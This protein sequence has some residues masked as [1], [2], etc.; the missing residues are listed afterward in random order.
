MATII[1]GYT[2]I[3]KSREDALSKQKFSY[4]NWLETFSFIKPVKQL[5]KPVKTNQLFILD[6][7]KVVLTIYVINFH[8]DSSFGRSI[9]RQLTQKA[10]AESLS[11]SRFM[12]DMLMDCFFFIT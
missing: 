12:N 1:V 3:L 6:V 2:K 4:E 7:I 5:F 10:S 11:H 8:L 9:V